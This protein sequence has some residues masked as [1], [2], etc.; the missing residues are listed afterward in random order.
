MAR[1]LCP[2]TN[3]I[4]AKVNRNRTHRFTHFNLPDRHEVSSLPHSFKRLL[5]LRAD[6]IIVLD[7]QNLANFERSS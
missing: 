4:S 3:G 7:T 1:L 2:R 5:Q 6:H